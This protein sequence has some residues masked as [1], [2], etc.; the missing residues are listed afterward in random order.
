[1]AGIS[2]QGFTIKRMTEILSDLRAEA[3]SL[4]QDL[5][6]PGDQVDTSSSSALGRLVA[7]VSPS[8]ADLWE[9]AQADYQAFDPNS[10]TGIALDNLVALGG[11]TRQEQTYSTAQVIISGDNGTLVSSGLT[12][13]SSIDSSQWTIL[14]PVALSPS[15][16]VG[17]TVTPVAV[18]N[19]TLYS[20]TYT[21]ITTAN[22]INFTSDASATAA[23]IVAGL[24]AVIIASH[25]SLISS[26]EGT[27]LK[28]T[29]VD[30]FSAV[31]F[32]V[33]ANL[34][35]TKVQ[36]LGEVRSSVVG[37]I[38]AEAGTLTVILTPQLGWD[39]VTNPQ[40]AS[41]GRNLET[42]EELRLRFRETK[43]ERASNIL[44]ALYSALINLEGVEEVRIYEND[45]D[46]VDA[47]GVPA[48]SFMPI[49]LGG[50]SIDIANTIWENKPMGIRSYGDTVVVIY[51]T[52]GFSHNIGFERPDPLPV[53]ITI[54]LTTDSEFPGTGVDD[55]KSALIAYF[56]SN[57]GIGDDVIWSRLF[58]PINTVKGHEIDSLFIGTSPTPSGAGSVSVAFDM[59]ASLSSDNIQVNV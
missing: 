35:I 14:S 34:G 53:Y 43:F 56:D 44:E 9:V 6:V 1:M 51:D 42:D 19:T 57:L 20:I 13:G 59:I 41:L 28:I 22:T 38:N 46:V 23:E 4:F 32:S 8:L 37:E 31:T 10:A 49:V 29:R 48:H 18:S 16:A 24:N 3:T 7:L 58:T 33:T 47:F 36:K 15:Q 12:V 11:I 54:N 45:T 17:V 26:I 27:S 30:E 25:P 21:S 39:S 50:V 55:I 40:A 2:D 5:V 52:Q